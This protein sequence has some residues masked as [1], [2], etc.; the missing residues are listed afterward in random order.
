M[1]SRQVLALSGRRPRAWCGFGL[2]AVAVLAGCGASPSRGIGP[3]ARISSLRLVSSSIST[4]VQVAYAEPIPESA[5]LEQLSVY[6]TGDGATTPIG[7]PATYADVA[8]SPNGAELAAAVQSETRGVPSSVVLF[9]TQTDAVQ[10]VPQPAGLN[11]SFVQWAPNGQYVALLGSFVAVLDSAGQLVASSIAPTVPGQAP[12]SAV[13]IGGGYQ[14]SSDSSVFTALLNGYL[15]QVFS[16]GTRPS[17]AVESSASTLAGAGVQVTPAPPAVSSPATAAAPPLNAIWSGVSVDGN[18]VV[19]MTQATAQST[20]ELIVVVGSGS[21]IIAVP[22]PVADT[23][24]GEL[25]SVAV[26]P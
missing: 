7:P 23:R 2:V 14:W 10:V 16:N 11:A 9:N 15:L 3:Q 8:L 21:A 17:T 18:G 6:S 12:G 25:I 13:Q 19:Y 26:V 4:S 20:G 22:Y 5:G 24:G 1:T